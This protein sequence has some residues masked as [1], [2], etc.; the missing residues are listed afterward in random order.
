M[1]RRLMEFTEVF[2]SLFLDPWQSLSDVE[3][4]VEK[5][6]KSPV[7]TDA[8][9]FVRCSGEESIINPESG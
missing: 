3:S 8:K 5:Q 6:H 9:R 7:I 2:Y 1:W 4:I